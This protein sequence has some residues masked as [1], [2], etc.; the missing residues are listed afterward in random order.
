M[1]SSLMLFYLFLLDPSNWSFA[2]RP[3]C[4]LTGD[5]PVSCCLC[6]RIG[7]NSDSRRAE[8]PPDSSEAGQGPA[9]VAGQEPTL[10]EMKVSAPSDTLNPHPD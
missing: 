1:C 4:Q 3:S 7:D 10:S 5:S 2:P 6:Y 9:E 8:A